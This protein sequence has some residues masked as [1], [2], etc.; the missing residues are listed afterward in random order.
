METMAQT[1]ADIDID[2]DLDS[3]HCFLVFVSFTTSNVLML[4]GFIS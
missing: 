1:S 3:D 2:I 4:G